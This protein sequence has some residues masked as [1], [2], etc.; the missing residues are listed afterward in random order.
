MQQRSNLAS[1]AF[2]QSV[3]PEPAWRQLSEDR[4]YSPSS[5]DRPCDRPPAINGGSAAASGTPSGERA[6]D[7]R[8]LT[9]H[10]GQ[11][12]FGHRQSNV[13]RVFS[14]D[15]AKVTT[16]RRTRRA[17][18]RDNLRGT[19]H[20]VPAPPSASASDAG[21]AGVGNA[22]STAHEA[23]QRLTS[24]RA[25]VQATLNRLTNQPEVPGDDDWN[26]LAQQLAA[27]RAASEAH[28]EPPAAAPEPTARAPSTA[29]VVHDAAA[30]TPSRAVVRGTAQ[31]AT[32]LPST[33]EQRGPCEPRTPPTRL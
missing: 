30:A 12:F 17:L 24:K 29:V 21:A 20:T 3:A 2:W 8:L 10:T 22:L 31:A 9:P 32:L 28:A 5:P 7:P 27:R 11:P 25:T 26:S 13:E 6:A 1:R 19:V 18:N 14:Y 23:L 15:L 33:P 4:D 16:G